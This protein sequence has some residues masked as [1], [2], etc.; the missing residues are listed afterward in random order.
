[1]MDYLTLTEIL[2]SLKQ[3]PI[4]FHEWL[5]TRE[6]TGLMWLTPRGEA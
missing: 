4:N 6:L 1:M 3:G 2:E 5:R